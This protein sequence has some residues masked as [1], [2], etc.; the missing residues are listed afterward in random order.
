M[1]TKMDYAKNINF[2]GKIGRAIEVDYKLELEEGDIYDNLG[3]VESWSQQDGEFNSEWN[4]EYRYIF[5]VNSGVEGHAV[6][7]NNEEECEVLGCE[8][9]EKEKEVLILPSKKFRIVSGP[10]EVDFEETGFYTVELE[11]I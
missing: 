9:C 2:K 3:K 8:G 1:K 5:T 7:Y 11:L 4:R 6:D 10:S